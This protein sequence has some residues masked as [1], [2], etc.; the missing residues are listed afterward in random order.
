M[1]QAQ[2]TSYEL[3]V[4]DADELVHSGAGHVLGDDDW[5][6]DAIYLAKAGLAVLIGDLG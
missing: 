3:I 4:A 1:S 2:P 6:G 5:A